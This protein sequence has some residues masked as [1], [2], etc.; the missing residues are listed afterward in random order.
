MALI[1]PTLD[2]LEAQ[3]IG[4]ADAILGGVD[5]RFRRGLTGVVLTAQVGALHDA[6]GYLQQIA[7]DLFPDSATAAALDRWAGIWGLS[8]G[9]ATFSQGWIGASGSLGSATMPPIGAVFRR[10]DGQEFERVA[11]GTLPDGTVA[12]VYWSA[13]LDWTFLGYTGTGWA[14]PVRASEPGAAGNTVDASL[15]SIVSPLAGFPPTA[16]ALGGISGAVD[17]EP[18]ATL[19]ARVLARMRNPPQGGTA[20]DFKAWALAASSPDDPITRAFVR[21]PAAGN[22]TVTVYIVDD[23]G[24][25][26]SSNPPTPTATAI[27]N[28]QTYVNARRPISSQLALSS[29]TLTAL[30]ITLSIPQ[31]AAT[32]V[33]AIE[34]E[35]DGFL[36]DNHE[37]GVVIPLSLLQSAITNAAGGV[38][39]Q[40][41]TPSTNPT[42]ATT[43]GLYYRGAITW[44]P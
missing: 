2:N 20:A 41:T 8:R 34:N 32:I 1:R 16:A 15:L 29:P 6:F 4:D 3:V 42:P 30:P 38:D 40:I 10:S 13:A 9:A 11:S 12:G 22:N 21:S 23:G 7:D 31:P 18:D 19:R 44:T 5:A 14:I 28:A 36:I 39:V 43:A 24:G 35:I 33:S 25:F 17:A 37:P 27:S 26:P